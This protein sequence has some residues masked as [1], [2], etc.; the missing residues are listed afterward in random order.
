MPTFLLRSYP[1]A[2]HWIQE[3]EYTLSSAPAAGHE[4]G[5]GVTG[6]VLGDSG[7][8][9]VSRDPPETE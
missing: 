3:E 8:N 6:L 7:P 2:V 9:P 1:I 4:P 5:E